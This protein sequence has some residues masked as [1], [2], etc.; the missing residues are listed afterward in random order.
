MELANC[1]LALGGDAGNTIQKFEVTPS[2]IA[3]LRLIHG[4]DSVTEI[5]IIGEEYRTGRH[6]RDRLSQS[7]GKSEEGVWSSKPVDALFPGVAARLFDKFEELE[8]DDS[9]YKAERLAPKKTAPKAE[10]VA[11][12]PK[13]TAIKAKA[14]EPEPEAEPEA[15][16]ADEE[17]EAAEEIEDDGIGEMNDTPTIFK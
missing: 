16:E 1:T 15:E 6:E 14:F 11:S 2:E 13:K 8:L 9:F 10:P 5:E 12:K 4:T 7:Y 17:T 3:V